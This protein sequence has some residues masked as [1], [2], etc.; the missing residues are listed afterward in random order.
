MESRPP[1]KLLLSERAF[2]LPMGPRIPFSCSRTHPPR[3]ELLF[4]SS[5]S[6]NLFGMPLKALD[7]LCFGIIPVSTLSHFPAAWLLLITESTTLLTPLSSNSPVARV[8]PDSIPFG[9][10]LSKGT[11]ALSRLGGNA[12]SARS[13]QRPVRFRSYLWNNPVETHEPKLYTRPW[14]IWSEYAVSLQRLPKLDDSKG[15][16][17]T[18]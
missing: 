15:L 8:F 7:I 11:S 2:P 3:R 12:G 5:T 1:F 14:W 17:G 4:S 18:K 10:P 13:F 6:K 9:L 16:C